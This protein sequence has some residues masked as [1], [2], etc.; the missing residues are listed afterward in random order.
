MRSG[1]SV[2]AARKLLYV[3]TVAFACDAALGQST[4][5]LISGF[6]VDSN[7]GRP[8][9]GATVEVWHLGTGSARTVETSTGGFYALPSLSPGRY[10]I[11]ASTDKYHTQ[12][13]WD[14]VLAVSATLDTG[15]RLRPLEDVWETSQP[16]SIF[17]PDTRAI[18][19]LYGPDVDNTKTLT[20][21]APL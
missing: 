15:F 8:I 4:Q 1:A 9:A 14:V 17:L 6:I 5:G 11:R 21:R 19:N 3:C 16:R 18:V 13:M 10:R 2:R 20:R 7:T 12:E